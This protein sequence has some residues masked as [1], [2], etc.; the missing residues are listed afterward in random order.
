MLKEADEGL[1][2]LSF[3]QRPTHLVAGPVVGSKD[4]AMLFLLV[5]WQRD[6][7]LYTDSHPAGSEHRIQTQSCLVLKEPFAPVWG[8]TLPVDSGHIICMEF[9]EEVGLDA[10]ETSLV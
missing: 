4:M 5:G 3:C 7:L 1:A 10:L 6:A 9:A 2:I 8:S